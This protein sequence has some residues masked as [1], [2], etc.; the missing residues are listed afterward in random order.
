MNMRT[1]ENLRK[2]EKGVAKKEEEESQRMKEIFEVEKNIVEKQSYRDLG[3]EEEY[4]I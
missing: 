2:Y 4:Q 1:P 3:N